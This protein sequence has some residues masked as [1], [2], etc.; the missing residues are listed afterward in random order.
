[1]IT[2]AQIIKTLDKLPDEL[3]IDQVIDELLYIEK[4]QQGLSDSENDR[5]NSKEEAKDKLSKWLK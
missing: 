5:V 1:M 4:V 2:K 3:S